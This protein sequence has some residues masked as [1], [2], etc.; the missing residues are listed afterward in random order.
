MK[1]CPEKG[2]R[3]T[4][5]LTN[6]AGAINGRSHQPLPGANFN[7]SDPLKPYGTTTDRVTCFFTSFRSTIRRVTL[8]VRALG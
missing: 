7:D 6:G 8:T 2:R 5:N 1:R 3:E 4:A